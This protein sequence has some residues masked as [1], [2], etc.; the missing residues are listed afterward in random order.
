MRVS[1]DALVATKAPGDI[2][3]MF[4]DISP[5]YDFLNHL[6]SLNTDRRWRRLVACRL[7][8][9]GTAEIL[10]ICSGTGDLALALSE[11]AREIG[12]RPRI[13]GV[14]F[15]P[16]MMRI[17]AGKFAAAVSRGM[18]APHPS[19]G[20]AM[21]L[22]FASSR[23]DLVTVAFGIRNV[24]DHRAG[25][26]EMVRVCRDGGRVGILEFSQPRNAALRAAYNAYFFRVLPWV[27]RLIS[28]SR[29]YTY[30]PK[31]V[32]KFPDGDEFCSILRGIAGGEVQAHPLTFGI[33]TLYTARVRKAG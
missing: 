3:G 30:L 23:F 13:A 26:A 18:A 12:A 6:L 24:A 16:S 15:T 17:G 29:A 11:R 32:A 20:D 22:P 33:A 28:G 5:T 4:H 8:E 21:R 1:E 2:R 19:V 31:S 7:L 14:D 10:D 27:G 25:V 9:R